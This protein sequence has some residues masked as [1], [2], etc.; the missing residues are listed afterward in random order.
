MRRLPAPHAVVAAFLVAAVSVVGASLP[1][2]PRAAASSTGAPD[3][4]AGT[5][6]PTADGPVCGTTANGDDEWLGIPYAAPP[7]GEL[8]WQPPQ[9]PTP[10]AATR[11]ATAFGSP[12]VQGAG[13][14]LTGSEDCLFLNVT[15]PDDGTTGLPVLVHIHS[16]GFTVGS[17]NGDYTLLANAGHVLVVSMNYR[18]GVLGFL[19][20][21]AFGGHAGDYGLQDQQAALR[22]VRQNVAAFGGDP[23]DV[24]IYGESAGGS[25][26][27]DALVSPTATGLFQRAVSVSGEYN[28]LLGTPGA[29]ETQDC[30]SDPPSQA[31]AD[32]AEQ[33]YAAALGCTDPAAEAACLR[34]LPAAR[35]VSVAGL[36]Y[37]LGG[38]GTIGP[39]INGSTLPRSLRQALRTGAVN[40][41]PVIAGTDR[42][43]DL[44]GIATSPA[45]YTSLVD[46]LYGDRAAEVTSRYP[47]SR[48]GSAAIA[49]RTIAADSNTV[50][51][52]LRTDADLARWMPVYGYELDDTDPP[53]YNPPVADG[54]A[55]GAAHVSGWFLLPV[56]NLDADQQA[57]QRN[58]LAAVG[59]FA[60]TGDPS[61]TGTPLWPAYNR[62]RQLMSLQPA[63]DSQLVTTAQLSAQHDCAFWDRLAPRD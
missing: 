4:A 17:G 7:V 19:A 34:G 35:A 14:T 16:G 6:V 48:F 62:T 41:V 28:N 13:P 18:L 9:P 33:G 29:L 22:W 32:T 15:R 47:L 38:H 60:T 2:S 8:R 10:W 57:L 50:C 55:Y 1:A 43:E 40:K 53:P 26:V 12:C 5:T 59:Q 24:T 20:G 52:A 3:C 31:A 21:R 63:G 36:G 51:P 45:A 54:Q 37:Q 56:A 27:C 49:F 23:S 25:S 61:A 39:T 58:E 46:R 42:D 30:K 44:M 11:P